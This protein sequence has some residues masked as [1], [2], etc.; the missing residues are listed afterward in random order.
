[1]ILI[2]FLPH[3]EIIFGVYIGTI[4]IVPIIYSYVE[5][6]KREKNG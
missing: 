6:K 2:A 3:V 4:T 1:M 5:Y